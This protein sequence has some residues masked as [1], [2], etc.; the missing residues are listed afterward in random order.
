MGMLRGAFLCRGHD[1]DVLLQVVEAYF[2]ELSMCLEDRAHAVRSI[3]PRVYFLALPV[4]C[5][6]AEVSFVGSA[7]NADRHPL[8]T[9]EVIGPLSVVRELRGKSMHKVHHERKVAPHMAILQIKIIMLAE[10]EPDKKLREPKGR[11][12]RKHGQHLA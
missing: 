10:D 4:P 6:V 12:K 3:P 7:G 11:P 9:V 1:V 5:T 2:V 8:A